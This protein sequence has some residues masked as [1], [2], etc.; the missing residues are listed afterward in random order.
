ML[1]ERSQAEGRRAASG[2]TPRVACLPPSRRWQTQTGPMADARGV[3]GR[4]AVMATAQ[5]GGGAS[6]QKRG[7]CVVHAATTPLLAGAL[8][9]KSRRWGQHAPT[10]NAPPS[11]PRR[12]WQTG[13]AC[14]CVGAAAAGPPTPATRAPPPAP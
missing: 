13:R 10:V 6:G 4:R 7:L 14:A 12:P 8:P 3:T 2:W 11:A 9:A 1:E 5:G